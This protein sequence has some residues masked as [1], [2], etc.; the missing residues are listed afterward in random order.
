MV[1]I[2]IHKPLLFNCVKMRFRLKLLIAFTM[3]CPVSTV[4]QNNDFVIENFRKNLTDL[5]A[6][7]LNV[8]DLNGKEA[9]LIR[10][11]VR[12]TLFDFDPNLGYLKLE[13]KKGEVWLYVPQ[14]TKRITIS[15]PYLGIIRDYEFPTAIESKVTY[16]ADIRITNA[17]Y[18]QALIANGGMTNILVGKEGK[19]SEE[20]STTPVIS[21]SIP[22]TNDQRRDDVYGQ[23]VPA[24]SEKKQNATEAHLL[25]GVGYQAV[26]VVGPYASATF[27]INSFNIEGGYVL[28]QK[29]AEGISIYSSEYGDNIL[30]NMDFKVNQAWARIGIDANPRSL[31]IVT[32]QVGCAVNMFKLDSETSFDGN[33]FETFYT[34]SGIAALRLQIA[35]H[36]NF[37]LQITPEYHFALKKDPAYEVVKDTD[38]LFKSSTE[39]FNLHAGI[40]L[41]I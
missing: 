5:T 20:E 31:I 18:M 36:K 16:T 38:K 37:R 15:H 34:Y 13:K 21:D 1:L 32:P 29:K 26:G 24:V 10:F 2:Y 39:G 3:L 41:R 22:V 8:K 25:F 7:S 28:G 6:I 14:L 23:I 17:A 33:P 35:I 4:A 19:D 9:A 40:I 12:D 30:R 27:S 11:A